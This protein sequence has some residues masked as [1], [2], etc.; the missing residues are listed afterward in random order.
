MTT[1]YW[2]ARA[3]ADHWPMANGYWRARAQA[4]AIRT[5]G[6]QGVDEV[7]VVVLDDPLLHLLG[8]G[9]AVHAVAVEE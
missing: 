9:Q 7:L 4:V 1:G 8:P 5:S 2:R 3:Q 6:L